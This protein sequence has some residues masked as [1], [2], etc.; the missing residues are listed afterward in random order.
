MSARPILIVDDEPQIRR[1]LKI[2]LEAQGQPVVEAGT[3]RAAVERAALDR[4]ALVI[5]DLGLPDRDGQD[6]IAEL[7]G[8]SDVPILVLSVREGEG[9]KIRAL[10]AGA[11][12]YLVKPFGIGELLARVRVLLRRK[13]EVLQEP[14]ISVHG[15]Q[16]DLVGRTVRLDGDPLKLTRKE[17]DLLALLARHRGKV[18]THRQLLHEVWGPAHV[19]DTHYLR[20]FVAQLRAKLHDDA[21]A[22][23]FLRTEPGIG[24]RFSDS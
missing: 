12:D 10:D 15:L 1:F 5:L 13:G 6:V 18:L 2:G 21:A 9:E 11:D 8:F 16:I 4:P 7:R 20:V 3:A 24:Y 19:E 14:V 17:F 23:R 22:P